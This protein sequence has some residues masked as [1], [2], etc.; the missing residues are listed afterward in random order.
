[1]AGRGEGEAGGHVAHLSISRVLGALENA[2]LM[3]IGDFEGVV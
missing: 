1:M 3:L 2:N